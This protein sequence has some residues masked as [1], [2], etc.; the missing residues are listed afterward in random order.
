MR[1]LEGTGE[2]LQKAP[3]AEVLIV[4]DKYPLEIWMTPGFAKAFVPIPE[5]AKAVKLLGPDSP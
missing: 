1:G 3:S 2:L 4:P 5:L